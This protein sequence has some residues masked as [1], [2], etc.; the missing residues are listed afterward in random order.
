MLI[1]ATR[2]AKRVEHILE[3]AAKIVGNPRRSLFYGVSLPAYLAEEEAITTTCFRDHRRRPMAL[4][5]RTPRVVKRMTVPKSSLA[6][7]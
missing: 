6:V 1:I 3:A 4:L 2:S 5:P 7:S